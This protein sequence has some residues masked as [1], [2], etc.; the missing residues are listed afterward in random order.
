MAK[1]SMNNLD[2][3]SV[4]KI[5]YS[6]FY[7]NP[8]YSHSSQVFNILNK[9]LK[10]LLLFKKKRIL[11]KYVK[12]KKYKNLTKKHIKI[13]P[14]VNF[15]RS[16]GT[17]QATLNFTKI[18]N[19]NFIMF[20]ILYVNPYIARDKGIDFLKKKI[21]LGNIKSLY[22]MKKIFKYKQLLLI[23]YTREFTNYNM[24]L[25][26][27]DST[28][29]CNK[30]NPIYCTYNSDWVHSEGIHKQAERVA[31]IR[32]DYTFEFNENGILSTLSSVF[33]MYTELYP[34]GADIDG[35]MK[36]NL[37]FYKQTNPYKHFRMF[38]GFP[39]NGQRT[40]SNGKIATKRVNIVK[41]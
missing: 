4:S 21:T 19:K 36:F 27:D 9:N 39:A 33:D 41:N 23:N 10:N 28:L 40:W 25:F 3:T 6:V 7:P 20:S 24:E 15:I 11:F 14:R 22:K 16:F 29:L 30:T 12:L 18:N 8:G 13:K 35:R 34:S 2:S 31:V 32:Y 26:I 5:P 1:S 17:Q 37:I 38:M